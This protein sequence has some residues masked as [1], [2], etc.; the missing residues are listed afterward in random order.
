MKERNIKL[1]I[2]YEGTRYHGWQRQKNAISIQETVEK[3][4]YQLTSSQ[5]NLIASGRTD[6]GVHA[7]G[8]VANFILKKDFTIEKFRLGLNACLP[9]DIVILDARVVP[10][11]FHARFDARKR[12]YQYF[13]KQGPVAISR[14]FCWQ[15]FQKLDLSLLDAAASAILGEHN[16]SAFSRMKTDVVNKVCHVFESYWREENGFLV[17][18]IVANRFLH[19]M[20]RTLVGTMLDVA[21]GYSDLRY[22]EKIFLL[23]DRKLAGEAVPARGLFLE[24]VHYE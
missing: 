11:K 17:Y 7:R 19:G 14:N 13:L 8:Q 1:L 20:V 6:A 5:V 21:R 12:V 3:A 18:R 9:S 4:I 16:F 2:E 24:A 10:E 22:F 15:Y 23:G